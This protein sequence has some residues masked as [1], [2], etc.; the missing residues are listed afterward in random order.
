MTLKDQDINERVIDFKTA[1]LVPIRNVIIFPNIVQP[2]TVGRPRSINA[3]EAALRKDRFVVVSTQKNEFVEDPGPSDMYPVGVGAEVLQVI[4]LPDSTLRVII[5]GFAR[6]RI[7]RFVEMEQRY[8]VDV[9]TLRT[10]L[11]EG[12]YIQALSRE[13]IDTFEQYFQLN[14]RMSPENYV[15]LVNIRD[16]DRLTDLI[17]SAIILNVEEKQALLETLDLKERLHKLL[18]I[19][20]REVSVLQLQGQIESEVKNKFDKTQKEYYLRE[21]LRAIQKEL[22]DS[23]SE[24]TEEVK[25]Y[26]EKMESL[27]LPPDIK[28]VVEDELTRLMKMPPMMAEAGVVRN[29]I[30]WVLALPWNKETPDE[31][32]LQLAK[33]MLDEDH[34]GLQDIKERILE[35]LAVRKLS[36]KIKAPILCLVGPPGVGKTSLGKS[37]ARAMG[38]KFIRMSLGGIRDEAE[39]RG[40]RRTY[41]GA[42][43]GRI[44]QGM[45][46]AGT[47]NPIF[48]LDEIDKIGTDFRGDPSSALL[49]ALDPEQNFAFSD[50]FLEVPFDLSKV[51]FITTANVSHTIPPALKD[52]M[53]FI[54]LSGYTED[55]KFNIAKNFIIKKQLVANGLLE[56]D[57]SLPDETIRSIINEYT[58]EAGLRNL[59]RQIA[60]VF[61]KVAFNKAS[62]TNKFR[63]MTIKKEKL[64]DY[65]K[66][67]VYR[68][69]VAGI[70]Y[71]PGMVTGLSVTQVGG[72][73]LFIE[74]IKMPGKGNLI[75]TGQLGDV[76]KESATAAMSYIRSR[77]DQIKLSSDFQEKIDIHIHVPEGAIPKDGPSAG[78]ALFSA[79][80]SLLLGKK[81]SADIA[82]TGEIT[83]KGRVLPIGGLKDKLLAAHR[84]GI[85]QVIIPKD[86]EKDIIYIDQEII[87]KLKIHYVSHLDEVFDLLLRK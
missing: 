3:I 75:L 27:D 11:H 37:V 21:Q 83:L 13:L 9:D 60:K 33:D 68:H 52:R 72:E 51:F 67:P 20:K 74:A 38:R 31:L 85:K 22:G 57:V 26:R 32:D 40:H 19:I 42:L 8:D 30:E 47:K 71:D 65:L 73:I 10:I 79:I 76:M 53:E 59:E 14:K 45:K 12:P 2:L 63:K 77:A 15:D 49:E 81:I 28:K 48:L 16:L 25:K 50:H 18:E 70:E 7:K 84:A 36:E 23:E 80:C 29:Y 39:I 87:N 6:V 4:R 82:M 86:N 44:I 58:S 56:S 54:N 1:P 66:A 34:Y 41:V 43:P 64:I 24:Y 69:E 17:S 61:R 62:K 5:E 78:I 55:E 35:Y 46:E